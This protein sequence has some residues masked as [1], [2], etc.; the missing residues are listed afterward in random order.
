MTRKI[1]WSIFITSF[2]T[3]LIVTLFVFIFLFHYFT[4]LQLKQ[5][6]QEANILSFTYYEKGVSF[7]KSVQTKSRIT[8]LAKNGE[9]I[10]DSFVNYKDL[11]NH[12]QRKEVLESINNMVSQSVRY[13]YTLTGNFLY[14]AKKLDDG[15]ILRLAISQQTIFVLLYQF[16]PYFLLALSII[17]FLS[18]LLAKKLSQKITS[19]IVDMNLEDSYSLNYLELQPLIKKIEQTQNSLYKKQQDLLNKNKQFETIFSK[20]KEAIIILNNKGEI[21]SFNKVAKKLFVLNKKDIGK[22]FINIQESLVIKH[23]IEKCLVGSKA[24]DI[25]VINEGKFRIL[26]QPICNNNICQEIVIVC[27]DE[28]EKSQLERIRREF[29]ANVAHELRTPL[30]VLS[31]YSEMLKQNYVSKKDQDFFVSKIYEETQRMKKMVDDIL[32]LTKIDSL[33]QIEKQEINIGNL[34]KTVIE[35][36]QNKALEKNISFHYKNKD[37]FYNANYAL[38]YSVFYNLCDNA[39]KYN[40]ENGAVKLDVKENEKEIIIEVCDTGVGIVD[41]ELKRIFERFYRIDK[42]RSKKEGGV[43]LGLSIVKHAL[44]L[45]KAYINIESFPDKGTHVKVMLPK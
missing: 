36:L 12:Y 17:L 1:G 44:Q 10:Y 45:H 34:L 29:T 42:S 3:C 18:F 38:L 30:H 5:L 11:E 35:S 2:I 9:V 15:N 22:I 20:M 43:G 23:L 41:K 40:K 25:L 27:F 19:P 21:L 8:L 37:V 28:T 32:Q 26:G 33:K 6:H 7:L 13:S 31:G 39:I 14:V 4:N 24:E 16:I